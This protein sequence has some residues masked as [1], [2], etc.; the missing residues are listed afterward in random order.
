[1]KIV[2]RGLFLLLSAFPLFSAAQYVPD[3]EDALSPLPN[4][5]TCGTENYMKNLQAQYPDMDLSPEG[6][7][8]HL[9]EE[10]AKGNYRNYDKVSNTVT[11]PVVVH[12][13]HRAAAD[14]ISMTRIM[15]NINSLNQD[16]NF[17]NADTTLIPPYFRP[18]AGI[19]GLRF[20]LANL[21]PQLQPTTG[22][23]YTKT[24]V[25]AFPL[26]NTIKDSAAGGH[27]I[28][29]RNNYLNIWVG[30][31]SGSILGYA[32]MPGGPA[33]SDGVV[34]DYRYFGTQGTGSQSPY[35]RGRTATHEVGH[36]FGLWHIWGD[37]NCGNDF[38]SDTPV[39]QDANYG[40]PA[41]PSISCN[42]GA[43]NN[44]AGGDMHMN[45][46]D[47]TDDRCMYMFTQGQV[48][49]VTNFLTTISRS[50]LL[51]SYALTGNSEIV[52]DDAAIQIF[53]NPSSDGQFNIAID[54]R[55]RENARVS[56]M[57]SIGA[58]I[59]I[60]DSEVAQVNLS[61]FGAG[62]YFL[63]ADAIKGQRYTRKLIVK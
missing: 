44:T 52:E 35:N 53:P 48:T 7:E 6:L 5:R 16:Y 46:M 63:V 14:S 11:I 20:A 9:N 19:V 31:L 38:V 2:F 58:E 21:D 15:S 23:T 3:V 39:S 61:Q 43:N 45:Y 26:D 41:Y 47:Y 55:I 8:K 27:D 4:H 42:N 25:T 32:Q 36:W 50:G 30:R 28:W 60:L 17:E 10:L 12:V 54:Y 34:V 13:V 59:M 49:R 40:C 56:V 33:G 62:I 51:S 37:A 57:N 29:D 1:M 22:V 18:L 24:G